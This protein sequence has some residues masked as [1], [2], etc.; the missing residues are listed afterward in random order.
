MGQRGE[1]ERHEAKEVVMDSVVQ[2]IPG[3]YWKRAGSLSGKRNHCN[4]S[5]ILKSG[6]QLSFQ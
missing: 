3:G 4:V 6:P 2:C 5:F 1:C